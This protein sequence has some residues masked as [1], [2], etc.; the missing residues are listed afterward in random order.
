M[1]DFMSPAERR[2]HNIPLIAELDGEQTE[3]LLTVMD[4]SVAMGAALTVLGWS[5]VP[6][7]LAERRILLNTM[8]GTARLTLE[9]I[10]LIGAQ[11]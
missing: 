9:L 11:R 10:E 7:G 5:G 3:R 6:G 8:A 2:A 4:G 1:T